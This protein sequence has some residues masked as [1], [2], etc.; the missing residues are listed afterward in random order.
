MTLPP[1]PK[2]PPMLLTMH[3]LR[4]PFE[5]LEDCQERYGEAF[6]FRLPQLPPLVVFSNP[7]VVKTVFAEPGETLHAG[8]FNQSLG[9]PR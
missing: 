5:F 1:G 6:T 4:R 2:G 7:D 8:A 3:W 9:L